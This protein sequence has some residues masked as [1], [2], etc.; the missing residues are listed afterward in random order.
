MGAGMVGR[1]DYLDTML[2]PPLIGRDLRNQVTVV[3]TTDT[4]LEPEQLASAI[5]SGAPLYYFDIEHNQL[6]P[7]KR[8]TS[9]FNALNSFANLTPPRL[10]GQFYQDTKPYAG[11]I[12][13]GNNWHIQEQKQTSISCLP[14]SIKVNVDKVALTWQ[15]P[16]IMPPTARTTTIVLSLDSS[17]AAPDIVLLKDN[18]IVAHLKTIVDGNLA[19]A[20]LLPPRHELVGT[21][22]GLYFAPYNQYLI[23]SLAIKQTEVVPNK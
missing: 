10:A 6:L 16:V 19:R 9:A 5:E 21:T 3:A 20:T 22:I 13:D 7:V 18:Q 23:K 14:D 4:G 11:Q 17:S 1:R 2:S 15:S 8:D 12:V